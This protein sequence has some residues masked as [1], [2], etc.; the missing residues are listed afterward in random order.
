M[1]GNISVCWIVSSVFIG[2][3]IKK[4]ISPNFCKQ[5]IYLDNLTLNC[6]QSDLVIW[7]M[8]DLQFLKEIEIEISANKHTIS[9]TYKCKYIKK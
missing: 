1:Y 7:F 4:S 9:I 3:E 2:V 6:S 5:L 8:V